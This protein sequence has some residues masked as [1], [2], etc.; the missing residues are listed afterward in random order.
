[1]IWSIDKTRKNYLL[2]LSTDDFERQIENEIGT[3]FGKLNLVSKI[4]EW[5]IKRIDVMDPTS[6]RTI[7]LGDA[8]HSIYP[9]AGQGFNLAIGDIIQLLETLKW[10]RKLGMD[11]G[12]SIFLNKYK[13]KRWLWINSVTKLTDGIDWLFTNSS[14]ETQNKFGIGLSLLE[15]FD[16]IK[17]KLV[18][19]MSQN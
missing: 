16:P 8:S 10:A 12:S 6:K 1:M 7:V 15:K 17:R 14:S 9:L 2:S 18:S 11:F 5:P 3:E 4:S 13:N 19:I